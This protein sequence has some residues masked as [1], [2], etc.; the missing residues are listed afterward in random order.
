MKLKV[1]FML[2]LLT[3]LTGANAADIESNEVTPLMLA[4]I[5]QTCQ[6]DVV[7][8][9]L[10]SEAGAAYMWSCVSNLRDIDNTKSEE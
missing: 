3:V 8:L 4:Q 6:Q 5:Q 1:L 2:P 7:K 9:G 10:G